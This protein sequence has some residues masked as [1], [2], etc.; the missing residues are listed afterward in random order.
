MKIKLTLLPAILILLAVSHYCFA[1][2]NTFPASGNVGI[3]TLAPADRLTVLTPTANIG[4]THT[5]GAIRMG[6]YIGAGAG[7]IGTATNHPLCFRT[8]S[9]SAQMILLQS[10]NF[11]IGTTSPT[12]RLT[13]RSA[14]GVAG[15]AHTDG[16]VRLGS[17]LNASGAL[18]GTLTNHPLFFRTNN[19]A[20]QV[21]LLQNGNL[22]IAT[23]MPRTKLEVH[24][25]DA[26]IN[27]VRVGVG[28]YASDS[29]Y[30]N[31]CLGKEALQTTADFFIPEES[32]WASS[33]NT[34]IGRA[35][36]RDNYIG[37]FNTAVGAYALDENG[38]DGNTAVGYYSLQ[39]NSGWYNSALGM[40]SLR[41]NEAGD[42]N[43]A[44]GYESLYSNSDGR[45]NT[46]MGHRSLYRN[47]TANHNTA[48]GSYA[49]YQNTTGTL[50]TAIGY[51]S[52]DSNSTGHSNTASGTD[53]LFRNKT[54]SYNTATGTNALV[55]NSTGSFNTGMGRYSLYY[56]TTGG[57]NTAVGYFASPNI[58]TLS[59]TTAVG[60]NARTT[61]SNQV[62]IGNNS[63]T[64][65]GGYSNWTNISDGRVKKNIKENVPGLDFI[66][67]LKPVT[68]N[69]ALDE[70]DKIINAPLVEE[71][72]ESAATNELVAKATKQAV[73]YTGFVAQDVEKAAKKISFDFS[74]VDAPKN[75]ND[76]YGL[77]Y[78]EFVVPLVKSVQELSSKNDELQQQV[79]ELKT[80]LEEL[81]KKL[82]GNEN[83]R[84]QKVNLPSASLEQNIPNPLSNHTT[85]RYTLPT[86][87]S[88]A[89][90]VVTDKAGKKIKEINVS[91][92]GRSSININT[93]MLNAGTYQYSLFVNHQLIDTRQ[94]IVAR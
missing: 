78:A 53:A 94:M 7:Y 74:G 14:S 90:I 23:N 4:I 60:Y 65:I 58:G 21:A 22:G 47:S 20:S 93:T 76:L 29:T 26:Y 17:M 92:N 68:Y 28:G 16:V 61:A 12:E 84:D 5:D 87:Y 62:R 30:D 55:Y 18:L 71:E 48:V 81:N 24:G 46:A 83:Y 45:D 36:L 11:G 31:T 8:N 69:L 39:K 10:G 37:A 80:L 52:L 38:Q 34:A 67:L 27:S 75:E 19:G 1:Q 25:S 33:C 57:T 3:G 88:Q 86:K 63:V 79:D 59:N 43:C 2:T 41:M 91:G 44:F 66:N 6:T 56:N 72:K 35:A 50:N 49:M 82:S 77:R 54:G 9:S 51:R 15:F 40:Q 73:Q 85:V 70:M 32:P 64:S 89:S 13:V 42:Y